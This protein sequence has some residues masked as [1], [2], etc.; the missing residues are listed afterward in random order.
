MDR[1]ANGPRLVGNGARNCLP[2]PPGGVSRELIAAAIFELVHGLHQTDIAFLNQI[3]ELQAAIGITLGDADHQAQIGLDQLFLRA[4]G[5]LVGL[6]DDLERAAEFGAGRAE[7]F[8]HLLQAL[9]GRSVP[10]GVSFVPSARCADQV[11]NFRCNA[12]DLVLDRLELFHRGTQTVD[13]MAD[14]R[15]SET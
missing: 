3:Q 10:C 15:R 12:R 9:R 2:H 7:L 13:E 14:H 1:N 6:G 4:L 8:F 11:S 5:L